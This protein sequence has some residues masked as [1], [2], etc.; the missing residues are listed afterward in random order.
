MQNFP[1]T[2]TP[3]Y[4]VKTLGDEIYTKTLASMYGWIAVGLMVASVSAWF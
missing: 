2:T 4:P 3:P 1:K